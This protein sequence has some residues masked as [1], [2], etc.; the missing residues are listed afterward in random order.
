MTGSFDPA[1]HGEDWSLAQFS[2]GSDAANG[3]GTVYTMAPGDSFLGQLGTTGDRD[4]VAVTLEAGQSYDIALSGLFGGGGTLGDAYLR[5]HDGTG[6]L[7]A[8]NDDGGAGLDSALVFTA[9]AT[10]TYYL[11]AGGFDDG[12]TGTYTLTIDDAGAGGGGGAAGTLDEMANYLISGYWSDGR[13]FFDTSSDNVITVNL[14]ALTAEGQQ[15]ARWALDAW[16]WLRICALSKP[17]AWPTSIS[18]MTRRVPS[19]GRPTISPG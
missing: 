4:W 17:P 11:S 9:S 15:L 13:R 14:E 12:E 10:G 16:R 1:R 19:P 7:V 2:E 6:A 5:I 18:T 8:E 3:T